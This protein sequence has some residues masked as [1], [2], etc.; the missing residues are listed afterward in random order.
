MS[1][2]LGNYDFKKVKQN[3]IKK[4]KKQKHSKRPEEKETKSITP[5]WTLG[6]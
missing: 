3:K 2:K 5:F 1:D 6:L 4:T